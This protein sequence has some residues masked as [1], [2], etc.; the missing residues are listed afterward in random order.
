MFRQLRVC[1]LMYNMITLNTNIFAPHTKCIAD[2]PVHACQMEHPKLQGP[3][4]RFCQHLHHAGG[5]STKRKEG[6]EAQEGKE[7]PQL[8]RLK[9]RSRCLLP[10]L[11]MQV[12]GSCALSEIP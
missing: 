4:V 5:C 6:Q 2:G 3:Q 10:C 7:G 1:N 11:S 12:R 9:P 8:A